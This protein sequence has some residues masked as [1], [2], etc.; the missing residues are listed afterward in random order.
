MAD[1]VSLASYGLGTLGLGA[2]FAALGWGARSVVRSLLPGWRAA[3]TALA[4]AVLALAGGLGVAQAAGAVGL[5][6]PAVVLVSQGVVGVATGLVARRRGP[7]EAVGPSGDRAAAGG[8]DDAVG[9]TAD[10]HEDVLAGR[11][12]WEVGAAVVALGVLVTQWVSH[13][14]DAVGRGMVHPDTL[15]YHMPFSTRFAQEGAFPTLDGVGYEAARWFPFDSHLLHTVLL[16]PYGRDWLSP[17]VNLAWLALAL[18]AAWCIG[19]RRHAGPLALVWASVATGLPILAAT[20]PGQASTDMACSALLLAALALILESRWRPAP[21]ALAGAAAGLA[22]STKVS[23]AVPVAVL[24]LL[25]VAVTAGIRRS[26]PATIAWLAGSFATGTFWFGRNWVITGSPLPWFDLPPPFGEA[27]ADERSPSLLGA[28]DVGRDVWDTIY[29]PGLEQGLGRAWPLLLVAIVLA[30]PALA[31]RGRDRAER[32]VGV[33]VVAAVVGYLA[34]PL[35]AGV[36][37][38]FNLRYLAPGFVVA[39]ATVPLLAPQGARARLVVGGAGLALVVAGATEGHV[40][41]VEAWPDATPAALV[42][43]AVAGLAASA[44][45]VLR[46]RHPAGAWPRL[47]AVALVVAVG[48]VGWPLQEH[49]AEQRYVDAGLPPSDVPMESLRHVTGERV[50]LY[51]SVE[52]YPLFGLD[53]SNHV[54]HGAAP[55]RRDCA[56]WRRLLDERYDV[57]VIAAFGLVPDPVPPEVVLSGDPDAVLVARDDAASVYRIEG[58]LAAAGCPT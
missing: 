49:Q 54:E 56:G 34:T 35:T 40:E 15:W 3:P 53:L 27:V 41:R 2:A 6:R 18:L 5:L 48:A 25:V 9:P 13:T 4:T 28:R 46:R 37:F 45:V 38:G 36:T 32:I 14:L 47:V 33:V 12:R 44:F 39:A 57:V 26:A 21:L 29:Q 7:A 52:T 8:R 58:P 31:V 22:L 1:G 51:G 19:E 30:G 16:M 55:A 20:H 23:L 24:V 50:A 17:Y 10:G 11:N 42:A 43:V